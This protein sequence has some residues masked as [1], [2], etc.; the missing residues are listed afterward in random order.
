[1]TNEGPSLKLSYISPDM[2][3]G[4]PGNLSVAVVYTLSDKN[5]LII[6][7]TATT[8]KKT[9]VNLTNHSYFNLTGNVKRNILD[10]ELTMNAGKFV[11]VDSQLIP[12]GTLADVA[13]TPFD[14]REPVKIGDRIDSDHPQIARG[15]GY[16]HCW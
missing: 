8:D 10:H 2:E 5:E 14:F 13:G 11:P 7:Y 9:I 12:E 6:D 1:S 4:Y 16:D 15:R 3:E